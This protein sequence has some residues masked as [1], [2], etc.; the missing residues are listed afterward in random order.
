MSPTE[1]TTFEYKET[2][3]IDQLVKVND[4][5][6]AYDANGNVLTYGD[7]VYTWERGRVLKSITEGENTY[8]YTY[9]EDGIRT[10]KTVNGLTTHYNTEGGT[11]LS[12]SNGVDHLIFEYDTSG[13]PTGFNYNGVHFFYLT[14]QMGDVIGITDASGN[15]IAYYHYDEWGSLLSIETA[16][17]GNIL[18]LNIAEINPIRY[19]GYYYDMETE[20][21]YLQSRYYD[22]G[23]GR[24]I[25]ADVVLNAGRTD[26][27]I[28]NNIYIY[29][30][31]NP[32]NNCDYTGASKTMFIDTSL[33][34]LLSGALSWIMAGIATSVTSIK[35]AIATSWCIPVCV[36]AVL[37]AAAGITYVLTKA[38]SLMISATKVIKAV[39]KQIKSESLNNNLKDY[40]VYVIVRKYTVDV[41]YVGI[42]KNYSTRKSTHTGGKNPRFPKSSYTMMPIASGLTYKQAR[43]LEQTIITAYTLDTLDNMIN[44]IS[45]KRWQFF[46]REF[47]Q[48]QNLILSWIEN[49]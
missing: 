29:C 46:L 33:I 35:T 7:K 28:M 39:K 24:F 9:D 8:S 4:D 10:S 16:E 12:Q 23:I 41:V 31:N 32:I 1:T 22:T 27:W 43:A 2:G 14:N 30:D 44:S 6:L 49:E 17:E 3:W 45:I 34:T 21:Y 19:R 40:T 13:S 48:M 26:G 37:I 42:T 25:N 15:P 5:T 36:A 11:L 20:Y 38:I 47:A 18:Q